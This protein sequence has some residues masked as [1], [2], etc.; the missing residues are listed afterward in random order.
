MYLE[1][2]DISEFGKSYN[3][4]NKEASHKYFAIKASTG[5]CGEIDYT[6]IDERTIEIISIYIEGEQRERGMGRKAVYI[7]FE[8]LNIDKILFFV[9]TESLKF[10]LRIGAIKAETRDLYY[11][12]KETYDEYKRSSQIID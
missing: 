2:I 10:W 6:Y 1:S 5:K 4:L 11:L 12:N 3:S 7:L 9:T 8:T